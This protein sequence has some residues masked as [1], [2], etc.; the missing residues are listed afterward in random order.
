MFWRVLFISIIFVF[1]FGIFGFQESKPLLNNAGLKHQIDKRTWVDSV[2]NT[3]TLD[4]KIGQFFMASAFPDK[5]ITHKQEISKLISQNKIGGVLFFKGFPTVQAQWI[6][7]FQKE[8]KIPLMTSI[9]GEWGINMRLDSSIQ[10]PRQLTLGAIQDNDLIYEMG[11]R[12]AQECKAVGLNINLAPVIDVNNNPNNPVINDRSFGEDKFN[13]ALKGL[14]Y[15]QGMQDQNVMAVGKHFPGHGDTDADSHKTLPVIKHNMER[16]DNLELY[17]FK[18]LFAND[19]MG[20]MAAHLFIPALDATPNLA[21][22]LSK[23][24]TTYLL[25]DSLGFKGLVFSDALNMKGVSAYYAPGL[26]D[27][28]AFLAGNDILLYSEDIPKGISLIKKA[29]TDGEISEEYINERLLT[30]LSYKYELGLDKTPNFSTKNVTEFLNNKEGLLIQRRLYEKAITVVKNDEKLIPLN[31]KLTTASLTL[32]TTI[33]PKFLQTLNAYSEVTTFTTSTYNLEKLGAFD[34]VIV[35]VYGMSRYSS[36]NYGFS[37]DELKI[38]KDLNAKT[39]VILVLFGSPYSLKYFDKFKNIIVAYEENELTEVA[40]AKILAGQM[41]ATGK[42]PVSAGKFKS[43]SGVDILVSSNLDEVVPS[44]LNIKSGYL[45]LID[46]IMNFAIEDKATPGGQILAAKDG[47]IFYNK[48]F[49]NFDYETGQAVDLNSIYDVASITKVAATTLSVMKLW[50]EN[51]LDLRLTIGHYLPEFD[52]TDI[53]PLTLES[54]MI[55]Q[56]G[57]PG[58][59]PFYLQTNKT[60]TIYDKWYQTR[61]NEQFCVQVAENMYMCADSTGVIWNSIRESTVNED[62]KYRYSDIGFY[63]MKSIV[64]RVSK[65]PLDLYVS[66]TFYQPLGISNT[67]FLPL[68]KFPVA[69][70]VPTENDSYFR[71]QRIQGH[72]HDMGAA[73]LGGVSGHAGLFSTT[74]DLAVI[75]QMLLN[76]GTYNDVQFFKPATVNY[77]TSAKIAGNRRG[78]GF[79]KPV[80]EKNNSGPSSDLCSNETFG[81]QGFTGCVMWADPVYNIIYVFLSNRTYPTMQN[82][83]LISL[84]VRTNIQDLIYKAA[85]IDS[86]TLN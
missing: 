5:D 18:T 27:K 11:K 50:E 51:K 7:D 47:K 46:S 70:I 85:G 74:N 8:S 15:M 67:T 64:E 1:T 73:M 80:I 31:K 45:E 43:G 78:L 38:L 79:D 52:T 39:K 65:K 76:K 71:N 48:A 28:L 14:A 33:Y 58:W 66:E 53:G 42:L 41:S 20:V 35:P 59:I 13:V 40:V 12:I 68:N 56:S 84:N 3:M 23:K 86:Y 44:E 17:P 2:M 69:R 62:P 21:V 36:K 72:V 25:K 24:V 77:F 9:D 61:P 16:L 22:S 49:G 60:D 26:V 55:H 29:V 82:N 81:H 6:N 57:L 30:V 34:Q 37:E 10:Y 32:G 83:K 19:L 4:Q 54:V 75:L 63:L